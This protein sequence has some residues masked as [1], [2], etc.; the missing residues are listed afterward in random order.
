MNLY[1]QTERKS[2]YGRRD[3]LYWTDREGVAQAEVKSRASIKKALLAI[4]TKGRFYL[5]SGGISQIIRWRIGIIMWR[6]AAH[7]F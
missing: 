2:R 1:Q 6:N 4:G 3:W 5:I 7:G